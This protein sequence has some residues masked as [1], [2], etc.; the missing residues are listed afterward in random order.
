ME[1]YQIT[2]KDTCPACNGALIHIQ[3]HFN[4]NDC[5]FVFKFVRQNKYGGEDDVIVR[6][7]NPKKEA[8]E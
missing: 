5:L 7:Q 6:H 2:R 1:T 8:A 3:P 4:C